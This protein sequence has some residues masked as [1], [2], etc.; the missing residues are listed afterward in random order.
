MPSTWNWARAE[1]NTHGGGGT[2]KKK[3]K[4]HKL[5]IST[6]CPECSELFLWTTLCKQRCEK[7]MQ[8]CRCKNAQQHRA[9][10]FRLLYIVH[11]TMIKSLNKGRFVA[12]H[13]HT[14]YEERRQMC[15]QI[16]RYIGAFQPETHAAFA[17]TLYP[18]VITHQM[19]ETTRLFLTP[20][21]AERDMILSLV[22]AL[23]L[24]VSLWLAFSHRWSSAFFLS[25]SFVFFLLFSSPPC[26]VSVCFSFSPL[27]SCSSLTSFSRYSISLLRISAS[28]P[29]W[30]PPFVL[31]SFHFSSF[32]V[33][34][35]FLL[36][37]LSLFAPSPAI[38]ATS[39]LVSHS[40]CL[41]RSFVLC[42]VRR[43]WVK[44]LYWHDCLSDCWRKFCKSQ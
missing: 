11:D 16:K 8:F 42:C 5:L 43:S 28:S 37:F 39:H 29:L 4:P 27:I 24:S 41:F 20:A 22:R 33:Q 23:S 15:D 3:K 2:H 38:S 14:R 13:T 7:C 30:P 17:S 32:H 35:H 10:G 19:A 18:I 6:I 1:Y 36:S 31:L 9:S 26:H 21:Q 34:P 12:L 44:E 25:P 40:F